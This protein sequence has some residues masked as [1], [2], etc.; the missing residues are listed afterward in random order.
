MNTP[1]DLSICIVNHRTPDLLERCLQSI[2]ETAQDLPIEILVVNNTTDDSARVRTMV[3]DARFFQNENPLGFSANQNRMFQQAQGRY[4]MPLNSDTIVQPGA[5][6]ELVRFMDEQSKVGIAGPKLVHADGRLQPSCRNFPNA[7][8]HFLEASGLWQFLRDNSI[9]GR[10]Y[11]LCSPHTEKRQVDWLTAACLIVRTEAARQVGYF[12]SELFPTIYGE[13]IEWCW[14]MR[15]ANWQVM[16]DPN[17][18]IIHLES[19]SPWDN[20][21]LEMYR[22]FYRFCARYYSAPRQWSIR[23]ATIL[24]LFPRWVLAKNVNART[25]FRKLMSLPMPVMRST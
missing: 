13:D 5:L 18:T 14:R 9:I 11:Y 23:L 15:Q 3:G 6:R 24:A 10:W 22:G 16:F 4:V 20:R 25:M 1:L 7:L 12:D 17:A 21:A 19:S 2:R 8:T